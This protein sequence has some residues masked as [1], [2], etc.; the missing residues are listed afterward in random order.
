VPKRNSRQPKGLAERGDYGQ[1]AARRI[2]RYWRSDINAKY[3]TVELRREE[4]YASPHGVQEIDLAKA[5]ECVAHV[6]EEHARELS[7]KDL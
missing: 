2:E 7:R 5:I 3:V 6:V 1:L 4:T